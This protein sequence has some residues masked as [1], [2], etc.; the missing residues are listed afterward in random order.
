MI[1]FFL[2]TYTFIIFF[3]SALLLLK[4][5]RDWCSAAKRGYPGINTMYENPDYVT[6]PCLHERPVWLLYINLDECDF[7][8]RM[9]CSV[10][11]GAAIGFE[12][13]TSERPV[14]MRTMSLVCLG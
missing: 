13:K 11:Y 9:I 14:G 3:G 7:A 2:I 8:T 5:E 4:D 1:Y 6:Y 10:I 12:R